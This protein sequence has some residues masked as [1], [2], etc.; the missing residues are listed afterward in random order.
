[1]GV[2]D[3]PVSMIE[4]L[5]ALPDPGPHFFQ[6]RQ[7]TGQ[8]A[9]FHFK[10]QEGFDPL[11]IANIEKSIGIFGMKKTMGRSRSY[12]FILQ[13]QQVGQGLETFMA[14]TKPSSVSLPISLYTPDRAGSSRAVTMLVPTPHRSMG[15]CSVTS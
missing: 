11:I 13:G 5:Q 4:L 10:R 1:M 14:G 15:A 9:V 12:P 8:P 2:Y 3:P 7:G 6:S